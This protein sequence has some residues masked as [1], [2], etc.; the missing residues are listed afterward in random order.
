[1][2]LSILYPMLLSERNLPFDDDM[3]L[4]EMKYDGIRA[5]IHVSPT[6]F[7]IDSRK[8]IDL[9]DKF[10]EL[11]SLQTL[12]K[13]EVILDGEIIALHEGKPHFRKVME[14]ILAKED[15]KIKICKSEN[16]VLF[17]AFDIL[18]KKKSLVELPLIKRKRILAKLKEND[19][20][21]VVPYILGKGLSLYENVKA[22]SLEGIVAKEINSPYEMGMRTDKWIK[23]K[24]KQIEAFFIMGYIENK[25][26][27]MSL[28]LGEKRKG[29]FFFCGKVLLGKKDIAS[30]IKSVPKEKEI[31]DKND[32]NAIYIKPIMK[33]LVSYLERSDTGKLRHPQFIKLITS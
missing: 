8:G 23:I 30:K 9:T 13:E 3:Y 33:C 21:M 28:L 27:T 10:P 12:V 32:T 7:R 18:Y 6:S 24:N 15:K 20:L 1:M 2:F 22:L 4:F 11:K 29:Q 26:H 31:G 19:F 14:R 16:P 17:M 5:I 25:N